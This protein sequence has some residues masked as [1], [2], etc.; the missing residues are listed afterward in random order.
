M[1]KLFVF[2]SI[3]T[4]TS[5]P[6]YPMIAVPLPLSSCSFPYYRKIKCGRPKTYDLSKRIQI[7][8]PVHFTVLPSTEF[9]RNPSMHSF[10]GDRPNLTDP[11]RRN[12]NIMFLWKYMDKP[13]ISGSLS[14]RRGA[15]SGCDQWVPVTTAWR[16]L[17]L[18][19]KERPSIWSVAANKLNKQSRTADKGWSSSLGGLR[20]VL[21][22]THRKS[23][24]CCASQRSSLG[25][26]LMIW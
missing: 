22:T 15:S 5:F 9:S 1:T 10:T 23:V 11:L 7:S 2:S 6:I 17:Q 20:E 3:T 24:S 13:E 25:P 19:R 14:P 8:L 12:T 18:Q 4:K 21:T 26:G 16:V